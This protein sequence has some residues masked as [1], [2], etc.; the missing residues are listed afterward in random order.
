MTGGPDSEAPEPGPDPLAGG[1][2]RETALAATAGAAP[3]VPPTGTA[4]RDREPD[5]PVGKAVLESWADLAGAKVLIDT[6]SSFVFIGT[7]EAAGERFL[8]LADTDAHDMRDSSVP[9]EVY[10]LEALKYGVR[11]NR[12]RVYVRV[13]RALCVSRLEDVI[14]Y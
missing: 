8:T 2:E 5:P 11:A 9:T 12:K 13:E 7:L 4:G 1:E 6:D 14:R 3:S 10:A